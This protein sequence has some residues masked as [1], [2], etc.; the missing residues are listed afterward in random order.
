MNEKLH[1]TVF[2]EHKAKYTYGI[3]SCIFILVN[4]DFK[5]TVVGSYVL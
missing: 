4:I 5:Y 1:Y 2:N 3:L